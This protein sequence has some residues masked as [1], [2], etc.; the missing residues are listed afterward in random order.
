MLARLAMSP[1]SPT[2]TSVERFLTWR[3]R[4]RRRGR[5]GRRYE[6]E[7]GIMDEEERFLTSFILSEKPL[8]LIT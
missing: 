6:Y 8:A 1:P 5:G 7:E 3:R 4:G 2:T